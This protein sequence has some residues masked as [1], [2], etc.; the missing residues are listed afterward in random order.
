MVEVARA[1]R[2]IIDRELDQA[3]TEW[4]R[5]PE[6][7]ATID[8]WPEDEA[9]DYLNEWSLQV[10]TVSTLRKRAAR[11]ELTP[12][13]QARFEELLPIVE[14]NRP[15]IDRLINGSPADAASSAPRDHQNGAA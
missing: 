1:A 2:S 3:H 12:E 10:D 9:L 11:G 5:L 14:R 6:V 4:A 15:I 7:E 13:Q 8:S